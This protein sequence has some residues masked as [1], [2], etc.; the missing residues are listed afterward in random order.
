[1]LHD[2]DF[3]RGIVT[4]TALKRMSENIETDTSLS[5]DESETPKK[6]QK[7]LQRNAMSNPRRKEN[8]GMSPL[9]LRRKYLPRNPRNNTAAHQ[10][11]AAAAAP[12]QKKPPQALQPPETWPA[13][14]AAPTRHPRIRKFKPGFETDTEREMAIAFCRPPRTYFTDLPFYPWLPVT[15][16]VQF[17]LNYK[18]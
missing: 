8:T 12:A 2:W 18:C 10:P 5:S 11:A 7:N 17:N 13:M 16:V 15:P 9:A 4:Q 1:M 3:R 6:A 14:F